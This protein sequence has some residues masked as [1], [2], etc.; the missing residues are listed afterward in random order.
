MSPRPL[1]NVRTSRGAA[2]VAI[3][4]MVVAAAVVVYEVYNLRL[5]PSGRIT[6]V[7]TGLPPGTN[8]SVGVQNGS[9]G[10]NTT[11]AYATVAPGATSSTISFPE[12]NGNYFYSIGTPWGYGSS[13]GNGAV[14]VHGLTAAIG[15]QFSLITQIAQILHDPGPTVEGVCATNS[16]GQ[17]GGCAYGDTMYT[18]YT[19]EPPTI[20]IEDLSLTVATANGTNYSVPGGVGGFALLAFN[21]SLEAAISA[22]QMGDHL[23]MSGG[24]QAYGS[25]YSPESL[26]ADGV[27]VSIDLG[28]A[29]ACLT[30]LVLTVHGLGIFTGETA[31]LAIIPATIC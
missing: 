2:A 19:S 1:S 31:P 30:G 16:S 26:L 5:G 28:D 12:R 25:S 15:I 22:G 17:P 11:T 24:W 27:I 14:S 9:G 29:N 18:I 4:V 21:W 23:Y 3:V 13:T 7:E 10:G 8:W 6:F 20:P